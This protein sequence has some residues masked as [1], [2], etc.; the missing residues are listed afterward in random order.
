MRSRTH[1]WTTT[2]AKLGFTRKRRKNRDKRGYARPLR[3]EGLE[4][5][6]MLAN[7]PVSL[8]TDVIADDGL[9]TL[10][11]AIVAANS[12]PGLDTI[13][14][15]VTGTITLTEGELPITDHLSIIGNGV[16]SLAI[17]GNH[18]N[19][20]FNIDNANTLTFIDVTISGVTITGG[21]VTGN[22]NGGGI[23]STENLTLDHVAVVGNKTS[24]TGSG[25]GIYSN[26]GNLEIL[27]STIHDNH[28]LVGGGARI[29]M[30]GSSI[31]DIIGSTFSANKAIGSTGGGIYIAGGNSTTAKFMN[32]TF[33]GNEA[34]SSGAF[35]AHT[36]AKIDVINCTIT[37]NVGTSG[38]GGI[39]AWGNPSS[40]VT[41]HNS[42]IVG[43]VS[44]NGDEADA[45]GTFVVGSS[46]NLVGKTEASSLTN[47]AFNN[48]GDVTLPELLLGALG[49]N[50]GP[51]KTYALLAG[52]PAI[53]AG[54]DNFSIA[55]DQR[56]FDRPFD[57]AGVIN[58]DGGIDIGAFETIAPVVVDPV[59]DFAINEEAFGSFDITAVFEDL[60]SAL[61]LELIS[62]SNPAVLAHDPYLTAGFFEFAGMPNQS[63]TA[64]IKLRATDPVSGLYAEEMFTITVNPV[65][66][67]PSG[68]DK[69]I[70]TL[71]DT[72]YTFSTA[73]FGFSD[74][75]EDHSFLG[76]EIATLPV[77]GTLKVHGTPV[78]VGQVVSVA[79]IG[80]GFLV[81]TPLGNFNGQGAADFTFRVQDSGGTANGGIDRDLTPNVITININSVNDAPVLS[82]PLTASVNEDTPLVFS[83]ATSNAVSVSDVDADSGEIDVT[84]T[85]SN[86]MTGITFNNI[87]GV[88]VYDETVIAETPQK[89]LR[90]TVAAINTVLAA[91]FQ[92]TPVAH[93]N[94]SDSLR[95]TV[96]DLGNSGGNPQEDN[97]TIDITINS[98]N[99]APVM[100][101]SNG[102]SVFITSFTE[103]GGPIAVVDSDATLSDVDD[104]SLTELTAEL[105]PS[106]YLPFEVLDANVTGTGIT[107]SYNSTTGKLTLSGLASVA[108]YQQVFRTITYANSSQ[109]PDTG[110]SIHFQIKDGSGATDYGTTLFTIN[111][112]NDA[113]VLSFPLTASVNEDTALVFSAATS[114]AVSV[115]DV[116]AGSGEIDVTLW[117]SP[118]T[119]GIT[120]TNATGVTVFDQSASAGMPQKRLH[121][122]VAA[123]NAVLAAGFQVTYP[124]NFNGDDNFRLIANDL[125][126]TGGDPE[127]DNETIDIYIT[128]VNDD[129]VLVNNSLEITEGV[130]VVLSALNLSATDIDNDEGALTFT[131]SSVTGGQFEELANPGVAIVSFTQAEIS[132]S[133]IQF[134]HNGQ[135]VSP[136]YSVTVSDG[137]STDGPE[138]A[139]ITFAN[140][141]DAPVIAV[142][143]GI[144]VNEGSTGNTITTAMLNEGDPDDQGAGLT[145]TITSSNLNG[146]LRLNGVALPVSGTFTQADVN[147]GLVTYDHNGSETTSGS[148][149]FSLADG[150][151]D[152]ATPV[153]GTF[154]FN[155]TPVNEAP[156]VM[157]PGSW[158]YTEQEVLLVSAME[159]GVFDVDAGSGTA[160]LT[161]S[162]GEGIFAVSVP[163]L[164]GAGITLDSGYGTN[165]IVF[166]GTMTALNTL[167][168]DP[169]FGLDYRNLSD[170]PSASSSITVTINDQGNTGGGALEAYEDI[171]LTITPVNDPPSG[172]N[173]T[174]TIQEDS[175]Y[176]F[177]IAD[178][179]FSDPDNNALLGVKASALFGAD[180]LKLDG[181]PVTENQEISAADITAGLLVYT[182]PANANGSSLMSF[183][184]Y[185]RDNGGIDNGGVDVDPTR[186]FMEINVTPVNDDPE[187]TSAPDFYLN[188]GQT[189]IGFVT[190][191]E[192]DASDWV[193][194]TKSGGAD[195]ELISIVN[196]YNGQLSF[197]SA[198]DFETKT[199]AN[200]DGIYEV[201][202]TVTDSTGRTDEQLVLVHVEDIND[203]APVITANQSFN[204]A[205]NSPFETP[206][207]QVEA[208][209]ADL[210]TTLQNWELIDNAGGMFSIDQQGWI[211][212]IGTELDYEVDQTIGLTAQV[213]DGVHTSAV[214]FL[215]IVVVDQN[216]F[217]VTPPVDT[218]AAADT[219]AENAANG[220]LVGITAQASDADGSNN[221]V[222]YSLDD[223]RFQIHPTTGVLTVKNGLLLNYENATSHNITVCATSSDGSIN[224][225]TFTIAVGDVDE[226]D[227]TVP[228]DV[229]GSVGG[230]VAENA[231]NG[232][233]VG[234]T[235]QASDADGSNNTI[236]YSLV[237]DRFQIH[238][239]TGVVTVKNGSLLDRETAASHDITVWATSSDGSSNPQTFTITLGDVN[240][241]PIGKLIDVNDTNDIVRDNAGNSTPVGIT[242]RAID[243]DS[244]SSIIYSFNIRHQVTQNAEG[245]FAIDS[246]TGV[247]VVA[248]GLLL[249]HDD[250]SEHTIEVRA[251]SSDG[252][253][254]T[255]IFV[256]SVHPHVFTVNWPTDEGDAALGDGIAAT[257]SGK[258][259]L[260]AA[261][262]EA[263]ALN[264]LGTVV[265]RIPK[266]YVDSGNVVPFDV[267]T[268]GSEL[269]IESNI[270]IEGAG[271]NTIFIGADG[272]SRVFS[273][274]SGSNAAFSGLTITGGYLSGT[275]KGAGI[276]N[277]GNLTL[278]EVIVEGNTSASA[279]GGI[280]S[281]GGNLKIFNS[282]I[283]GN[284]AV[285]GGG[286][287]VDTEGAA[288]QIDGST[289]YLNTATATGGGLFIDGDED[290]TNSGFVSITNSTVSGNEALS[291]AGIRAF[292]HAIVSIINST[293]TRNES[294]NGSGSEGGIGSFGSSVVTLHNSIVA[295]NIAATDADADGAFD[296]T[297]SYN[298]I[299]V[300]GTAANSLVNDAG[301][302]NIHYGSGNP[303]LSALGSYGG[304]TKSHA[305]LA[306]SDAIDAGSNTVAA[307]ANLIAGLDQRLMSRN[308]DYLAVPNGTGGTIDIGAFELRPTGLADVAVSEDAANVDI[309]D[310]DSKFGLAGT[311]TEY[312]ITSTVAG[313]FNLN[314][315]EIFSGDTL[316]LDFEANKAGKS[317]VTVS[318]W[319]NGSKIAEHSFLVTIEPVN[320]APTVT[321][322]EEVNTEGNPSVE[323]W[324]DVDDLDLGGLFT[325]TIS[326]WIPDTHYAAQLG[327]RLYTN[328]KTA[329]NPLHEIDDFTKYGI[330]FHGTSISSYLFQALPSASLNHFLSRSSSLIDE[331]I[332]AIPNKFDDNTYA[333]DKELGYDVPDD[334]DD[335]N[336][337]VKD[338]AGNNT[339]PYIVLD[340]E[341]PP[342]PRDWSDILK[343][344]GMDRLLEV[345]KAY[346]LRIDRMN[347]I[348][349]LP[350]DPN[351]PIVDPSDPLNPYVHPELGL[352][353]LPYGTPTPSL[354]TYTL[355]QVE[356][357]IET[358]SLAIQYGVFDNAYGLQPL[359]WLNWGPDD[360]HFEVAD[361]SP[362]NTADVGSHITLGIK[363]AQEA[364]RRA[365]VATHGAKGTHLMVVPHN[366]WAV[367]S[368]KP[369]DGG[370]FTTKYNKQL[371]P[372]GYFKQ[373]Q[374]L[375]SHE[376]SDG[377]CAT[378]DNGTGTTHMK[379]GQV[380][381]I[382]SFDLVD[383]ATPGTTKIDFDEYMNEGYTYN[384]EFLPGLQEIMQEKN[385]G[386]LS[387][388]LSVSQG[389]I[390]L[391]TENESRLEY[392]AG[393]N[394]TSSMTIKGTRQDVREALEDL[395]YTPNISEGTDTLEIS[396]N[397]FGNS[398]TGGVKT[399]S[400]E[401][402][403]H[404]T[405]SMGLMAL[406][407][408]S[409]SDSEVVE[410]EFVLSPAH[411][412]GLNEFVS[413]NTLNRSRFTKWRELD[414]AFSDLASSEPAEH[415]RFSYRHAE[416]A[417]GDHVTNLVTNRSFRGKV[418]RA[419]SQLFESFEGDSMDD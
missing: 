271:A 214:Q 385:V 315:N 350:A 306:G 140:V 135:E 144:T 211:Y 210:G 22:N 232:T 282:S 151:E 397:D 229:D 269:L 287:Y 299:G 170:S 302:H 132:A 262:E 181:I 67:A 300:V 303:G 236:T 336:E 97:E 49:E 46:H 223:D 389:T 277:A 301:D 158:N 149:G 94:G 126:N 213:S 202:I 172:E 259:T 288:I 405:E 73:D 130:T 244:S 382:Y 101:I 168:V 221:T 325:N 88:T 60:D 356:E 23:Y 275:N 348:Y 7:Y 366:S 14:F 342:L 228:A 317:W 375:Q 37:A 298:L 27:S 182:P 87:S 373:V 268:I 345:F 197:T 416:R 150:G 241:Q 297:S 72:S 393:A 377:V 219:V 394:G 374:S 387:V 160:R 212:F 209:D 383:T 205:E 309:N 360:T 276:S 285:L 82:F 117:G 9:Y 104:L 283:E 414:R 320:D 143:T 171:T 86:A 11:E 66:D 136:A 77:A 189:A 370:G 187:I 109:D 263:N 96:N 119:T 227:V 173:K 222:S 148:F 17:S 26:S 1:S 190:A 179:G 98:V 80:A 331:S 91:G 159:L 316:T 142:N 395:T 176:T 408:S 270:S 304:I 278:R 295:D 102:T 59:E 74:P 220:T 334:V 35:R 359:T 256:I 243:S 152:G 400:D 353:L 289:F 81:Y 415:H 51:T 165:E 118:D 204:L 390:T 246:T 330:G 258:T 65:N 324:V 162:A 139:E 18:E 184:F 349:N 245:R 341:G 308:F 357:Q 410:E 419:I 218:N 365:V 371:V 10:R 396:V 411:F 121:G 251:T 45:D 13:D 34:V 163:L 54:S 372:E 260:R 147:A 103:G 367:E 194:Y 200:N 274:A 311:P 5:R 296:A 116:D 231:A 92:L 55:F 379:V 106:S 326:P 43:N 155:V 111:S 83:A 402:T 131:V 233:L 280:Y 364:I 286:V 362:N 335:W 134:V 196:P 363:A 338:S 361:N 133:Q 153:G 216:E 217:P 175:S 127:E 293:I 166:L 332:L 255:K 40:I 281:L 329:A 108:V 310:L 146:M 337:W 105:V 28:A 19:R 167:L 352:R 225:Q 239:T 392:T 380:S 257:A 138:A 174:I 351:D 15:S 378:F 321:V 156:F 56:G 161:L 145:Y 307:T 267:L 292:D 20:V 401:I 391:T 6:R 290:G 253:S 63:G 284:H 95:L 84:L 407:T 70:T 164:A 93:Y 247:V 249:N 107:K 328:D 240:E 264:Q 417:V 252:T 369:G 16:D 344:E 368:S 199:D 318:A 68:E 193:T 230:A 44:P 3:V 399:G 314:A 12:N 79:N 39:G 347:Y 198:R 313:L 124:A 265:V 339:R 403:I 188:E 242:A 113:P 404:V 64:E 36:S 272:S 358:L 8:L 346:K 30:S 52:S 89:R 327:E 254:V 319:E 294:N 100:E 195:Q 279:G 69:T 418:D 178:F 226:F 248:N 4:D 273:I 185:V 237:D 99:D 192:V 50:G 386:T 25:G 42:I 412:K 157:A 234:I 122:T 21:E 333:L 38:E 47:T 398:G 29:V 208:T 381:S 76:V 24:T 31:I 355:S 177:T 376:I 224:D 169:S 261:I 123:I 406:S 340:I 183:Q 33:S 129:P 141:N 201:E 343:A 128:P 62:N 305:L 58:V 207:G 53:D 191:D 384:N 90:G 115:S 120:F 238:P 125:G 322:P 180:T 61:D 409:E 312:K 57:V 114:N 206:V 235:A 388:S 110:Q 354:T 78:T 154:N 85:A 266:S 215:N 48:Q 203:N 112:V 41:V 2:L 186:N 71:E 413:A 32:S 137:S 250:A 75:V 291:S 323:I